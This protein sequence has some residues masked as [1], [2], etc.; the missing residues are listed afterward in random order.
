M[1]KYTK[2][3]TTSQIPAGKIKEFKIGEKV[4]ALAHTLVGGENKYFAFDGLCTHAS[5]P[6][7]GGYLDG[8]KLTCYCHGA[9]FDIATGKVLAPPAPMPLK[10]YKLKI[11]KEEIFI[12]V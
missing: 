11:E 9:Q 6:L 10:V 7:A 3:T 2:L 1:G 12:E 8:Y 5:C 4:I